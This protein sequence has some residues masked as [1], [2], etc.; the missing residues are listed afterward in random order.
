MQGNMALN[1]IAQAMWTDIVS[2]RY[3][4]LLLAASLA[5]YIVV[6]ASRPN[7]KT[8]NKK[9]GCKADSTWEG[10][11]L[12]NTDQ[13]HAGV[14]S[15]GVDVLETIDEGNEDMP[16]II[17]ELL[18][19]EQFE[20]ACDVYEMNFAAFFDIDLDEDMERRLLMA[21]VK[22][23]KKSLAQHFLETSQTSV[24]KHV[25]TIQQ[26]WR[27]S[28]V[29]LSDTRVDQMHSVLDRVA[30]LFNDLHPFDEEEHSDSESTCF[31]GDDCSDSGDS[32]W[33]DSELCA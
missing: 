29:K 24:G 21:A 5:A 4:L 32:D 3:E 30:R 8:A 2:S 27:K 28:A 15:D 23:G 22:C 18:E 33:D 11:Q 13:G 14:E 10:S 6:L 19:S 16:S 26:W 12:D 20:K 1:D 25:L 17:A 9:T 31:L 7:Q